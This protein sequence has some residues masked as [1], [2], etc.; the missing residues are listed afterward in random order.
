M[1]NYFEITPPEGL[2]V[3][4]LDSAG[5]GKVQYT[6]KNV[7]GIRWTGPTFSF[8]CC[9]RQQTVYDFQH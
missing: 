5:R 6:E 8:S 2:S 7:S 3:V 4:K 1:A 9:D